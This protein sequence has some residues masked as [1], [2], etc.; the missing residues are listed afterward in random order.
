[1]QGDYKYEN[2]NTNQEEWETISNPEDV[3]IKNNFT[4]QLVALDIPIFH[5]IKSFKKYFKIK[6]A[7]FRLEEAFQKDGYNVYASQVENIVKIVPKIDRKLKGKTH[8][9]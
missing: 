1:M 6:I 2:K 3:I 9:V 5:L 7:K 4:Y 8:L